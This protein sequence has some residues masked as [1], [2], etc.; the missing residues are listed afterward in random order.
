MLITQRRCDDVG[1]EWLQVGCF[2]LGEVG[3]IREERL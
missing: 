3:E 2:K 1:G